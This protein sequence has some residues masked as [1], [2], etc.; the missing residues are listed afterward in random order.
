MCGRLGM[1][2][3]CP[4]VCTEARSQSSDR[5]IWQ[6]VT[7]S[8]IMLGVGETDEEV[9]QAL[10]DLRSA[11]VEIVTFG[12]VCLS[13]LSF[14]RLGNQITFVATCARLSYARWYRRGPNSCFPHSYEN[15][16]SSAERWCFFF[17]TAVSE[18]LAAAHAGVRICST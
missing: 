6:V 11:G 3:V 14:E 1:P 18:T 2:C 13:I 10:V 9:R 12:Q 5:G 17:Q 16:V 15:C 4:C 7:K 8:S